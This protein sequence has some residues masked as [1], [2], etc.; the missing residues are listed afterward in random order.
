MRA[1]FA[2]TLLSLLMG[3]AHPTQDFSAESLPREN[4]PEATTPTKHDLKVRDVLLW[5]HFWISAPFLEKR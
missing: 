2:I 3:C 4:Q 1:I 5:V